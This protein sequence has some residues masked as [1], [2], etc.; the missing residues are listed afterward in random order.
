MICCFRKRL[1]MKTSSILFG[2]LIF[3]TLIQSAFAADDW[4]TGVAQVTYDESKPLDVVRLEALNQAMADALDNYVINLRSRNEFTVDRYRF[5]LDTKKNA[6]SQHFCLNHLEVSGLA[7]HQ[8]YGIVRVTVHATVDKEC[9]D[10]MTA[11]DMLSP[12]E[13]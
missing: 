13:K 5:Y 4:T 7:N 12:Q 9:F 6:I 8:G 2:S 11:I 1:E 3:L 10:R